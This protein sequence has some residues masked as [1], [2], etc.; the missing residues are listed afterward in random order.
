VLGVAILAIQKEYNFVKMLVYSFAAG[1]GFA[2]AL[3]LMTGIRERF[4]VSPIPQHLKGTS[5]G[6]V[7]AGLL[8]LAFLGFKGVVH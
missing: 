7:T 6:L 4:A 3:V 1:V 5:I 2:V 8:A